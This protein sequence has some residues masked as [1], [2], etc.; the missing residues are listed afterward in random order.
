MVD[1]EQVIYDFLDSTGT[2]L[3]ELVDENIFVDRVED[4]DGATEK[5]I[6]FHVKGGTADPDVPLFS[7]VVDFFCYG[8]TNT[9]DDSKVVYR[10]L[11]DL[12]HAVQNESGDNG[13]I[14]SA[15]EITI[16]QT[17]IDP[18]AEWLQVFTSYQ[19][20]IRATS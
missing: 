13:Y 10:A 2:D 6:M 8:G 16:G 17:I 7:P 19:F 1:I 4:F 14:M 9:P 18:D 12:L 11:H 20:Q 15:V 3:K 5:G